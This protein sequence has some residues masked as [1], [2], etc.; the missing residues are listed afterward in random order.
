MCASSVQQERGE[1]VSEFYATDY[2]ADGFRRFM[3][4]YRSWLQSMK[5]EPKVH[6]WAQYRQ[7]TPSIEKMKAADEFPTDEDRKDEHSAKSAK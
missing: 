4:H 2:F 7:P 3:T 5:L 6:P 1:A